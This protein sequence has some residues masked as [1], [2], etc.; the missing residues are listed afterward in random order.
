MQP[1]HL[2]TFVTI[3]DCQTL[4]A[5]AGRLY[6]SQG[7]VSQDLR[8]L[9]DELGLELLDRS[10]QRVALTQAGRAFLP[11]ARRLLREFDDV[12]AEMARIRAGESAI[13]RIASLP[14]L[15]RKV[16]ALIASFRE[17][18]PD[19][20]WSLCGS[21]QRSML[22]DLRAGELDLAICQG[23]A[24]DDIVLVPLDREPLKVVIAERLPHARARR[25]SPLDLRGV[26]YIGFA[27]HVGSNMEALRF[28]D[29]GDT[30]ATPT[31]E[32]SDARLVL[33][34][35]DR[36]GGFGILPLSSLPASG[37]FAAVQPDPPLV[38]QISLARLAGRTLSGVV[39]EFAQTIVATW[40]PS[41]H[42]E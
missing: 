26:P 21:L 10:G 17:A 33:D 31:V 38:R 23:Q 39:N 2:E 28:F 36:L 19:V 41:Q 29:H 1:R 32:V 40:V 6:K 16:T 34:L 24:A 8:A 22:E 20:R 25:I 42:H 9:E 3:V 12:R 30:V 11:M 7:A 37:P 4:T 18:H 15:E 14:S 35:V 27:Q 5:A 13:V